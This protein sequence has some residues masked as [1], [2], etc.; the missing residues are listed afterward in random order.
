M[1]F[2]IMRISDDQLE[3]YLTL[4][5]DMDL[6]MIADLLPK[7]L[8]AKKALA[9][10]IAKQF[11]GAS[12]AS[13]AQNEFEQTVQHKR[14]PAEMPMLKVPTQPLSIL[15]L[16]RLAAPEQ[17][18]GQLKRLIEQGG[19][20]YNGEKLTNLSAEITPHADAVLRVGKRH[21]YQLTLK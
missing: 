12:A 21:Y 3:S 20:E 18:S 19:V 5:T 4:L 8:E 13:L 10:D 15:A 2:K 9:F 7:P 17:S 11:H 6:E 16:V 14:A 1:Y